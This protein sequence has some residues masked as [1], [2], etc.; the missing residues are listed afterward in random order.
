MIV[1]TMAR[2]AADLA[3]SPP[4]WLLLVTGVGVGTGLAG[5]ATAAVAWRN[6]GRQRDHD[7]EQRARDREHEL[8]LRQ[9]QFEH[10]MRLEQIRDLE[11]LR[12]ARLERLRRLLSQILTAGRDLQTYGYNERY[13]GGGSDKARAAAMERFEQIRSELLLEPGGEDVA[14]LFAVVLQ[15]MWR[16]NSPSGTAVEEL[17]ASLHELTTHS[18]DWLRDVEA[19]PIGVLKVNAKQPSDPRTAAEVNKEL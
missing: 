1:A 2:L 8:R 12:D 10:D 17:R 16:M 14:K 9:Q 4:P 5:F 18:R 13:E 6:A 7:R 3:G 15:A 19:G 11:Q